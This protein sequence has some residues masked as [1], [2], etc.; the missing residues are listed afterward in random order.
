MLVVGNGT[1]ITRDEGFPFVKQGAVAIDKTRIAAVGQ[2]KDIR[3]AYRDAEYIDAKGGLIM[4]AFINTHEHIYSA[5]AR[6]L[7]I[8]GYNPKGYT[9]YKDLG[10][11][12]SRDTK[13][14][15]VKNHLS[16]IPVKTKLVMD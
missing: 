7:S 12:H 15:Y 5:M 4:P 11:N 14:F 8:K 1:L 10:G 13:Y 3:E 9:A 16:V 2:E 6:G